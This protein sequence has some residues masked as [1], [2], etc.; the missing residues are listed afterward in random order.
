MFETS[1]DAVDV[2]IAYEAGRVRPLRFRWQGRVVRV[3]TGLWFTPEA[4]VDAWRRLVA[5][6]RQVG[7]FTVAQAR[8]ALGVTRKWALPLLEYFDRRRWTRREGDLRRVVGGPDDEPGDEDGT[9]S[10]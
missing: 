9:R 2:I 4:L 3:D 1:S 6:E 10:R 8:D 7:P 5:L